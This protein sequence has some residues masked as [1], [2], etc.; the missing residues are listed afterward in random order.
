MNLTSLMT[1]TPE[2]EDQPEATELAFR[3]FRL[4]GGGIK[5]VHDSAWV[6]SA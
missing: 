3:I 1:P 2:G 4:N 6:Q 5:R